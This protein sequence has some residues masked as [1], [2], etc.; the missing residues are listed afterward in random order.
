[1]VMLEAFLP[2]I[3]CQLVNLLCDFMTDP[4]IWL[5]SGHNAVCNKPIIAHL[6][7]LSKTESLV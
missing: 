2:F 4:D 6:V 3:Y 1:M 5:L 7:V